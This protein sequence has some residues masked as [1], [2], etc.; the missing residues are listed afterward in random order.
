[1]FI[2]TFV[3][4]F[5]QRKGAFSIIILYR[6]RNKLLSLLFFIYFFYF[7]SYYYRV[8]VLRSRPT[9]N[10]L[11]TWRA[12]AIRT[13]CWPTYTVLWRT[14]YEIFKTIIGEKYWNHALSYCC[15]SADRSVSNTLLLYSVAPRSNRIPTRRVRPPRRVRFINDT[16]FFYR[17]SLFLHVFKRIS[18]CHDGKPLAFS[19]IRSEWNR[20]VL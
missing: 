11:N 1:M 5:F 12:C 15:Y 17:Q 19:V 2:I 20:A 7:F 14:V 4:F 8:R 3:I 10:Y 18:F 13:T 6:G 16:G 9:A